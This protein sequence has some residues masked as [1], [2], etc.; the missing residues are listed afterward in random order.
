MFKESVK[1]FIKDTPFA[2]LARSC[3]R[4]IRYYSLPK[5]TRMNRLYNDQTS[6]IMSR[7]LSPASTCV[8]IGC[9]RGSILREIIRFAP[10]ATHFAFEPIP[11]LAEQLRKTTEFSNVKLYELALSDATGETTF[12]HVLNSPAL[13][14]LRKRNYSTLD[15]KIQEIIVRTDEL[16]NIIPPETK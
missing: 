1:S 10:N 14:G 13:S 16:D 15:A 5:K 7:I 3:A 9:N 12:Q 8:D 6:Q 11:E 4:K 2:P